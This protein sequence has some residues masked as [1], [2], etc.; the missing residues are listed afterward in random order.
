MQKTMSQDMES[1]FDKNEFVK[2]DEMIAYIHRS[3]WMD[4]K[5]IVSV[6]ICLNQKKKKLKKRRL[7]NGRTG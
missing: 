6:I 2:G 7:T 1:S 3:G 4:G 5:Y